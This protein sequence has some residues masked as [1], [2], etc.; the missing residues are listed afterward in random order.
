[1][2]KRI[3]NDK[4]EWLRDYI[5]PETTEK[6]IVH[7]L[8]QLTT[9]EGGDRPAVSLAFFDLQL[10]QLCGQISAGAER[11]IVGILCNARQ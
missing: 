10:E 9:A 8:L 6:E 7:R 4:A 1:M 3:E 11:A 2:N 5:R